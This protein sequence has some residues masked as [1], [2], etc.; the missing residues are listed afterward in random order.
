MLI[1]NLLLLGR[2]GIT[3]HP[4]IGPCDIN[5]RL[6]A[7][8]RPERII[9]RSNQ[10]SGRAAACDSVGQASQSAVM[11]MHRVGVMRIGRRMDDNGLT[12]RVPSHFRGS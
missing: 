3:R 4:L 5:G 10:W 6:R 9:R 7:K 11:T 2:D 12:S 1:G 8:S